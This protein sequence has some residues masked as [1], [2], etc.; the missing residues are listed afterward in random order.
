[1]KSKTIC[2]FKFVMIVYF[3]AFLLMQISCIN[4]NPSENRSKLK[5]NEHI[6]SSIADVNKNKIVKKKVENRSFVNVVE[7]S[8]DTILGVLYRNRV[9]ITIDK[10]KH[11]FKAPKDI[12]PDDLTIVED[13]SIIGI[14]SVAGGCAPIK[15]SLFRSID[16]GKTW[17][18]KAMNLK[19][20]FPVR[21]ISKP[22]QRLRIVDLNNKI[23][24]CMDYT[25]FSKWK[26][27]RS[28]TE[29]EIS[30]DAD[31]YDSEFI[32]LPYEIDWSDNYNI[33]LV[34][35]NKKIGDTILYL[36]NFMWI[37][38]FIKTN[39]FL[40]I[41]GTSKDKELPYYGV[42][43]LSSNKFKEI[44]IPGPFLYLTK[45]GKYNSVYVLTDEGLFKAINDTLM[46]LY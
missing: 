6:K 25:N 44:T 43:N 28:L 9:V 23:Q 21:I 16:F 35:W 14:F 37:S 7:I 22:Y 41:A 8:S 30:D 20:V 34:K 29:K 11:W 46:Q 5:K 45:T 31:K 40:Y 26:F 15:S 13:N 27:I 17:N 38:D 3:F 4:N 39:K 19:S 10:G 2:N 24:E 32:D 1:M 36:R 18:Q 42:Y 33:K 12:Y